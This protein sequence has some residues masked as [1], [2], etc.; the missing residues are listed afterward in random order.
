M[1]ALM[2]FAAAPL[3]LAQSQTSHGPLFA[4]MPP[5]RFQGDGASVVIFASDV[6][7][8]CGPAPAG[9]VKLGCQGTKDGVP[10]IVLPNPCI[11]GD[12]EAFARIACHEGA[13]RNGWG[14]NHEI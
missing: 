6:T 14:G 1:K 4:G 11:V 12:R 3:M 9:Y 8:Y 5:H 2:L 7:R 10:I 13:H